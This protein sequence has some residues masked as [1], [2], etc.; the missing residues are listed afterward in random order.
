MPK[1]SKAD[2]NK[3]GKVTLLEKILNLVGTFFSAALVL[4]L[5]GNRNPHDLI[6]AG[7]GAVAPT[8]FKLLRFK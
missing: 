6:A 1:Y 3:D 2:L 5:S 8:L 7:I 4:Y